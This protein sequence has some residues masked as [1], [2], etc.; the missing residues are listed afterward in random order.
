MKRI[1]VV[2]ARLGVTLAVA[3]AV[4]PLG[5]AAWA[6]AF[7]DRASPAVG[8]Q[9]A[10]SPPTLSLRYSEPVEPLFS[11]VQVTNDKGERVDHGKPVPQDGGRVLVVTLKPLPPGTYHVAWHVTSVDTHQTEGHFTFTVQR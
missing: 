5:Q 6:H 8:S 1:P 4:G 9:V 3:A 7:L 10:T 11:G 2:L